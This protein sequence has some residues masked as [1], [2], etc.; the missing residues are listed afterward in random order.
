[1]ERSKFLRNF[2][3]GG[4]LLFTAP[5]ILSSCGKE[6]MGDVNDNDNEGNNNNNSGSGNETV[7]DLNGSAYN[8]LK[9]VGGF[10]YSGNIIIIRTG[11]AQYIAM[12]KLCTHDSCTVS[13]NNAASQI[14]CPCHG[15]KFDSNG[16][17][18]TGPATAA[19]KK[20]MVTVSGST[21]KIS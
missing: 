18:L 3:A 21:L 16:G 9:S 2:V 10:A 8:S 12:S 20:Y 14:I 1:M 4:G 15:S 6:E 13:W 7:I 19:L 17:V 11:D 5:L